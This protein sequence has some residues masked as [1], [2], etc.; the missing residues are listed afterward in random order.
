[1]TRPQRG[2]LSG[3]LNFEQACSLCALGSTIICAGPHTGRPIILYNVDSVTSMY[4]GGA[5]VFYEWGYLTT[6]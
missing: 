3:P 5:S 1:M 6:T 4:R 2:V